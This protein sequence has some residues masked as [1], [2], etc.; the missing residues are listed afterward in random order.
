MKQDFIVKKILL[1]LAYVFFLYLGTHAQSD[2]PSDFEWDIVR[3]G[4]STP[5]HTDF[6]T[7]G[8]SI[9]TEVRYN[10]DNHF[11]VGLRVEYVHL[12]ALVDFFYYEYGY[13]FSYILTGD[14]HLFKSPSLMIFAGMGLGYFEGPS[15]ESDYYNTLVKG[16]GTAGLMSRIGLRYNH[17]RLTT[18]YN[19]T[20][21]RYVPHYF[22]VSLGF[23][24]FSD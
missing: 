22:G 17:I 5:I 20:F 12:H 19:R 4:Y 14:Y 23:T 15:V 7:P 2:S 11:A 16:Q 10:L 6:Y 24:L 9:G 18:E 3:L 1:T 8:L 13:E 21:N